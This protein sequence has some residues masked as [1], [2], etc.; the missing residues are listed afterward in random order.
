MFHSTLGLKIDAGFGAVFEIKAQLRAPW[1]KTALG[2][3]L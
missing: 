1:N 3:V 2:K